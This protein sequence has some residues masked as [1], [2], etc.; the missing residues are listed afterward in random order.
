MAALIGLL[1]GTFDPVHNGH[2]GVAVDLCDGLKMGHVLFILAAA[3]PHRRPPACAAGHRLA[4]LQAG[5]ADDERLLVDTRELA[6]TGPSYSV[7]TLRSLRREYPQSS[8][9]WIVGA[10]AWLGLQGW[11]RWHELSSLAHFVVVRRPGWELPAERAARLSPDPGVLTRR[12]AGSSVLWEGPGMDV[13][14]SGVRFRIAAG[15]DVSDSVPGAVWEYIKKH[16]LYGY[17]QSN[18]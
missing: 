1:G 4:M 8:L 12:T 2:L 16:R 11:Y 9:C 5:L 3:P 7:W 15:A 14:A 17:Q 6:R 10:D 13:S 18:V